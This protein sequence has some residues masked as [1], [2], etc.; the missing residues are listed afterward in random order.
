MIFKQITIYRQRVI[1]PGC[2]GEKITN[3][4]SRAVGA[5]EVRR[6]ARCGTC[7][8]RFHVL[9]IDRGFEN[10]PQNGNTRNT[11]GIP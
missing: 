3:Y 1:C 7:G 11:G 8:E 2:G 9:V 6:Y 5:G 10:R 4:G